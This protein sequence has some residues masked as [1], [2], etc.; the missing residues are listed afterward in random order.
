MRPMM[1]RDTRVSKSNATIKRILAA[2]VGAR[3]KGT[4]ITVDEVDHL[5]YDIYPEM[6]SPTVGFIASALGSG[7]REAPRP[8]L[9]RNVTLTDDLFSEYGGACVVIWHRHGGSDRVTI[10]V[11]LLDS[12]VITTATDAMLVGQKKEAAAVLRQ[13]GAY[14]GI[15]SAVVEANVQTLKKDA[16]SGSISGSG[17][18]TKTARTREVRKAARLESEINTILGR[19]VF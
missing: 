19:R 12:D 11:P 5:Q 14:A 16:S 10:Y 8:T 6:G 4:K 13:L 3:F 2:T 15:G 7:A 18:K 1:S 17:T 9:Q